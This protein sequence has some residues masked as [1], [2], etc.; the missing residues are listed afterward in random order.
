MWERSVEVLNPVEASQKAQV[1]DYP[2]YLDYPKPRKQMTNADRI[3]AMSDEELLEFLYGYQFCDICD[4][5]C[6]VCRYNGECERR[7]A[8][9][10]KQLAE[11]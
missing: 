3:R 6:D 2:P 8:D 7:L 4:E 11:G 1:K 9:W 10:L 5:G